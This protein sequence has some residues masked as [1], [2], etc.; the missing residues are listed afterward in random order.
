MISHLII[1]GIIICF[2]QRINNFW[3]LLLYKTY[4]IEII[5]MVDFFRSSLYCAILK[6]R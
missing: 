6:F 4:V 3:A 2:R 5:N 1:H